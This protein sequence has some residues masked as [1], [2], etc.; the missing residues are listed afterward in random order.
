MIKTILSNHNYTETM[1]A[2][3]SERTPFDAN[4]LR[5]IRHYDPETGLFSR[6][7]F[8]GVNRTCGWMDPQ[9]Y[10]VVSVFGERFMAHRL[11][12]LYMTDEWPT[13]QIDHI[14]HVRSDNRWSNLRQISA[15]LN[16]RTRRTD[17]SHSKS[18]MVGT[19]ELPS[20]KFSA[21][22]SLGIFDSV[23]EANEAYKT[24]NQYVISTL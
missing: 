21:R 12:H 1:K 17:R 23:E 9:G 14:N 18:G 11:A 4:S 15:Q 10:V 2:K 24:A 13:D 8:N 22:I 6:P 5:A 3:P 7:A 19:Y 16:C 20:G